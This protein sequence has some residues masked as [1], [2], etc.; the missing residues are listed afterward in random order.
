MYSGVKAQFIA[1]AAI[2][3]A[4]F[5]YLKPSKTTTKACCMWFFVALSPRSS[6]VIH[7]LP[8]TQNCHRKSLLVINHARRLREMLDIFEPPN[9][10]APQLSGPGKSTLFHAYVPT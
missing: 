1:K 7:S 10:H 9:A 6:M 2:N 5:S 8:N 4:E 3:P